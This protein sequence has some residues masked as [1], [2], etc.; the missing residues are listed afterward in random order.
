MAKQVKIVLAAGGV[1]WRETPGGRQVALVY[2]DRWGGEWS[3]P[4]GKLEKGETFEEAAL[5]EV[6]EETGCH[7][8]I[9]D[10]LAAVDYR[11]KD[12]P[13]VVLFFSMRLVDLKPFS[14]SDEVTA[15]EWLSPSA[16]LELL[17]H[18]KERDVLRVWLKTL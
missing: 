4:K 1:L 5:R 3:L 2:R 15:L 11:A 9:D 10:F 16:A 6:I 17:A 7:A 8:E 14:P 12:K 13:K 18:E